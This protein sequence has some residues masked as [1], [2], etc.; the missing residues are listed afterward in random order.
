MNS[1]I[2]KNLLTLSD[3][4]YSVLQI[5][6]FGA[7]NM[8]C[9]FCPYPLREDKTSKL[10]IDIL[11]KILDKINFSDKSFEYVTFSQFNEPLMDIRVFDIYKYCRKKEIPTL[12]ITN[13]LL[14]KSSEIRKNFILSMPHEVKISL[15]CLDPLK[16]NEQRGVSIDPQKY[17]IDIYKYL[18]ELGERNTRVNID[19]ACNFSN[20]FKNISRGILGI[21]QGEPSVELNPANLRVNLI[22]FI[23]K[24]NKFDGTF[25][26]NLEKIDK[27][28]NTSSRDYMNNSVLKLKPNVGISLKPFIYGRRI[29][30]YK[31]FYGPTRCENRI[32]G[33]LADGTVAPC[34]L[35]YDKNL[36]LGNVNLENIEDILFR[37]KDWLNDLRS[38]TKLKED[39]CKKCMGEPTK[40]GNMFRRLLKSY[41]EKMV[42]K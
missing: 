31:P 8:K 5:E 1:E 29:S 12:A 27:L 13:A 3:Y 19:V 20:R 14:F 17:F 15:Q 28:I 39:V 22:E 32:L 23:K 25:E 26:F 37:N 10:D 33:V 41:R 16:F 7:C 4:G 6:T 35:S 40:R 11:Y 21:S 38:F 18:S 9:Q 36:S 2:R 42:F 30:D 34:C 24:L